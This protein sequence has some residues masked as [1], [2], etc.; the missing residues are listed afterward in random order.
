MKEV[1]MRRRE[2]LKRGSLL[3][4]AVILHRG[5]RGAQ[6]PPPLAVDSEPI[7]IGRGPDYRCLLWRA[8]EALGG[9]PLLGRPGE[10]V[11]IKPTLAWN[12][13]PGLGANVHPQVLQGA[14][15]MALEGGAARVVI[16]DRTSL[17]ARVVHR[18]SQAERVVRG[19]ADRRV[20]LLALKAEDFVPFPPAG[21]GASRGLSPELSRAGEEIG[22]SLDGLRACCHL[23][24]A[25]RVVN[26]ATPR[27]HPTRRAALGLSNLLGLVGGWTPSPR[28]LPRQEA[29]LALLGAAVRPEVTILDATRPVLRN[30]PCGRGLEDLGL[31]DTLAASRDALAVEALGA[32]VLGMEPQELGHLD[33]AVELGLGKTDFE[34]RRIEV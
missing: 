20:E 14:I 12:R 7:A 27:H 26:I 23:L 9:P 13:P 16:C 15:E 5:L 32:I 25:H 22:A 18:V 6:A 24:E 2:F 33:P 1:P 10:T 31:L 21:A 28:W 11:L 3:A 8:V 30:G 29:D 4:A 19:L 17:P 34:R